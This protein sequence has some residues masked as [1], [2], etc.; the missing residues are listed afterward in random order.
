MTLGTAAQARER[1]SF[2]GGVPV[3]KQHRGSNSRAGGVMEVGGGTW[4]SKL[5]WPCSPNGLPLPQQSQ[6]R[7]ASERAGGRGAGS[8]WRLEVASG[9][10]MRG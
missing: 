3:G 8:S 10:C 7:W 6:V 1:R 9:D 2:L 4:L 5:V